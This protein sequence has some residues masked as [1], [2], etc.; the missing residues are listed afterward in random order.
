[1]RSDN[2]KTVE[3]DKETWKDLIAIKYSNDQYKSVKD[4]V[5]ALLKKYHSDN[6][7]E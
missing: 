1:M 3:V 2:K 6:D 5:I 7:E 4:V